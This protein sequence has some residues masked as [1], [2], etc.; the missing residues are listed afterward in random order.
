MEVFKPSPKSLLNRGSKTSAYFNGEGNL[1]RIPT[2]KPMTLEAL[3]DGNHEV[4]RRPDEISRCEVIVFVDF[5]NGM[6]A[7]DP[8]ARKSA[9]ELLRHPWLQAVSCDECG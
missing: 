6:L 5:L 4:T 7:L 1:L 3:I 9:K 8:L 2:L